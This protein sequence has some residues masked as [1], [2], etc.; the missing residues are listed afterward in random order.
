MSL[1][2]AVART[3]FLAILLDG[4]IARGLRA[5]SSTLSLAAVLIKKNL[6]SQIVVVAVQVAIACS[7]LRRYS[8]RER[9]LPSESPPACKWSSHHGPSRGPSSDPAISSITDATAGQRSKLTAG[10]SAPLLIAAP[11]NQRM[12]MARRL[13]IS[14]SCSGE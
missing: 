6:R 8:G 13:H 1:T 2:M 4:S 11:R 5:T 3:S 14:P 7:A 10:S 9:D 12:S